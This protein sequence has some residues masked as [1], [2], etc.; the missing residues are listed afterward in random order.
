M[1]PVFNSISKQNYLS[2]YSAED[3]RKAAKENI[4]DKKVIALGG[5]NDQTIPL[6]KDYGFGVQLYWEIYGTDLTCEL[7]GI[8]KN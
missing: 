4:I 7:I 3:I 5:I 8:T 1:S 6:I 2:T